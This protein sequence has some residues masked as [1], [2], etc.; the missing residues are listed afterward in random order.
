MLILSNEDVENILS[1]PACMK[2][3]EELYAD[4]GRDRALFFPRSDNMLP[5]DH[6]G[7]Y[8]GF[9]TMGGGWPR[10]SM[11]ALRVNSDVI[12]HPVINGRQRRVKIPRADGRWV[13]LVFLFSTETGELL[14]IFPDGVCQRMRVGAT[15]GLALKYLARADARKAGL[16]GTG[17]QA[18]AQLQALLATRSIDQVKVYSPTK[19]NRDAFV[20]EM[21]LKTDIA[22]VSVD[23]AETCARDVDI[24]MTATS[25]LDRVIEPEWLKPGMHVSCIKSQEIDASVFDRC[26]RIVT[27]TKVRAKQANNILPGT[28]HLPQSDLTGWWRHETTAPH[29]FPDLADLVTGRSDGRQNGQETTCFVNNIGL[30][31]QFAALGALILNKAKESG[32][33][34]ELPGDWFSESVHP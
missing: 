22:I 29:N 2:V 30:G 11:M 23:S 9:K 19:A 13:G 17:W 18:G 3:M 7:A 34:T 24:L 10:Y 33:G 26:D 32:I 6:A 12:T 4:F 1:M 14:S 25:S 21:R 15:N 20:Q 8:Y 16:I 5:C 31:L 27:H 28:A